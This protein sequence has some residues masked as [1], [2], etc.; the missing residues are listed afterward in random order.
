MRT[1]ATRALAGALLT[2]LALTGVA[3]AAFPADPPNDP[4]YAPAE[5]PGPFTCLQK[6]GDK[7]EHYLFSFIPRCTPNAHD[8]ENSAG[9]SLDAAWK[10][11]TTGDPNT[12]IAYIEGGINWR[13]SPR[14]L[15][16]KVFL[17]KGEL[18][19]PT[20]PVN[21][22]VLNARD[23]AD[24]HDYNGNGV[25]DPEDIIKR[26]SNG[27]DSDHNGY[28]DDISGWDF[29]DHQNDPATLD[30]KYQHANSQERQAASETNNGLVEAGVCPRCMILPVKAGAEAL[31][32]TDDLAQAWLYAADMRADVLV[33]VTADLGYSTFMR[34]AI[35]YVWKH[36][37]L[38]VEASNDFDSADHQGGMFWPHVIPGNAMVADSHGIDT[39][40][41]T[42]ALQNRLT[43]TYRA[44]SSFTSWGSHNIFTAA[45]TGGTTSEVTPTIGGV[46]ALVRAYGRQVGRRLTPDE[47]VQVVRATSSDVPANPNPP[48]GWPAKPGWD[49]QYGYGRPNALRAIQAVQKGDVPPEAW[50]E[51]PRWYSLSDPVHTRRVPITGHV[52]ARRS[53]NYS[54]R[55]EFA[56]GGEPNGSAFRSIRTGS[57]RH[58]FTGRLGTLDLRRVPR[59]FWSRAF[60]LSKTKTLE[61]NEQYTVTLRLRVRDANG[62]VAE[63]RR[64]IAVHHDPSL[65]RGFPRFVGPGGESQPVLADIRGSG[66]E[67][68]VFGDADGRVHAVAPSG[69]ELPGFPAP[70]NRTRVTKGHRGVD[71]GREPIFTTPAVGDLDHDGRQWIVA[72]SSSGVVYVWDS[73]GHRRRGWPKAM[74]TGV[75]RP[76][77]PRPDRPFTRIPVQGASSPPVLVDLNRDRRLEIV[78]A[79]WDGR[80]HAWTP[81][82]KTVRGFP[83]HVT[84]PPGTNPPSG[85]IAI[86]DQ[87]LDLS[88]AIAELDGDPTPELVQRT[89]YSFA[90]GAGLQVPNGGESNVLAY[91]SDGSR[92]PGFLISGQALAFDY[93]SAQEFITEGTQNPAT[94]DVDGDGKSEITSAAGIFSPTS[95]YGPDGK[96]IRTFAP[97]PAST[98]AAFT[99]ARIEQTLA[100]DL[101]NDTPVNFTAS[102][103]FGRVGPNRSL[104][105]VEPGSGV[106][107]VATA[108]LLSGSGAPINSYLRG[109]DPKSG[110]A[111]PG[112]P[113]RTQ[114]LDFLGAPVIADVS[115]DGVPET[116]EGGD[117]SALHA[118]TSSGAQAPGFPKF[119][120]GWILFGPSVGDLDGNSRNEVAAMTREG[121]LMVWN[122]PGRSDRGNAEWWSY[123][124]DERNTGR[125]GVDTRPPGVARA[126]RVRRG[127][128][129][130]RVPGT[131]WYSGGPAFVR[132]R[133]AYGRHRIR[134]VLITK[135]R[136][137]SLV[138]VRLP[139]GT[140]GMS[141]RAYD[142]AGNLGRAVARR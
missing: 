141:L 51:G 96:L 97:V 129:S 72:T 123:R 121:Y 57:G 13:D 70:T 45:T 41:G 33:S 112:T 126:V 132:V 23:Y 54:W 128:L 26:F 88:P 131:D 53:K 90:K 47:A 75:Q 37:T 3:F 63:E 7:Q 111:L 61:T 43:T 79:G 10:R 38:P 80:L 21:D 60:G 20:T 28:V 12:V 18:P 4:E 69:R 39:A 9:M 34:R 108:L 107:S 71:P 36:G 118:F 24:T 119:D 136:A 8:S 87:K 103:A 64:A 91:N 48:N 2:L 67:A 109:F 99:P 139:R 101:P 35:D 115:G 105:Y 56:P 135:R 77:I 17:N 81:R 40:P 125:F 116:I 102:G 133:I 46:L 19:K 114:G 44:R 1:R 73:R 58:A 65:R 122:T 62:R 110:N 93:G 52:A 124:H 32:R 50:F 42:A 15:A 142:A 25:V 127:V 66:S 85:Q 49:L 30:S 113:A 130:F 89:Q 94:A 27:R 68:I 78:Q 106:A 84:L 83:V 86:N 6:A 92:V 5:A 98:F 22:G 76:P 16:N 11:Y 82:G 95:L 134:R 137:G 14:E 120:T 138:R 55:L 140:H 59:S 117:S 74:R 31:D 29:Y 100:G 104:G